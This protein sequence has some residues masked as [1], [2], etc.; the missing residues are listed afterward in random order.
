MQQAKPLARLRA[1]RDAKRRAE[2][3]GVQ[4]D[5][6]IRQAIEEGHSERKVALAAGLSPGRVNQIVHGG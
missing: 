5:A 4:R 3:L 1:I 2:A 6:L